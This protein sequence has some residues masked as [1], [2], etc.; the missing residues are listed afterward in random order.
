M[1]MDESRRM[2]VRQR[3]GGA[4]MRLMIEEPRYCDFMSYLDQGQI[5]QESQYASKSQKQGL[6]HDY[7][8]CSLLHLKLEI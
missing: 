1:P 3:K 8:S 4:Q 5:Q 2:V 7:E 6:S